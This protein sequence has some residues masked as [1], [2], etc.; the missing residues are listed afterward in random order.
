MKPRRFDVASFVDDRIGI[1]SYADGA[2]GRE[3][4][5]DCPFCG[6][7]SKFWANTITGLWTCYK[8]HAHGDSVGLVAE[9]DGVNRAQ[10]R[11]M[12][13][14]DLQGSVSSVADLLTQV[15]DSRPL[16]AEV[17]DGPAPDLCELPREFVP[18]WDPS[19]RQWHIPAYLKTRKIRPMVAA[20]FKL[21]YCEQGRYAARLILPLY[22]SGQLITFQARSMVGAMPKYLGPA[23]DKGGSL[24]GIDQALLSPVVA[25]VEGPIDV[26]GATQV[27][28]PAIGMMGKTI[29][30]AQ[31]LTIVDQGY[32]RVVVMLDPEARVD[33]VH[34]A[35]QLADVAN[36]A[37]AHLPPGVDPGDAPR[38]VILQ[39]MAAARPPRLSDR[40]SR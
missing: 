23:I 32:D 14:T 2:A 13:A 16:Q 28:V 5:T 6:G 12:I 25:L 27:G 31:I 11:V 33:A 22:Q 15:R 19:T 17:P 37:V 7:A 9:I 24:Y 10:A 35:R 3:A 4:V 39:A 29:S 21:G 30:P 8:C 1:K 38:E 36:V 18:I 20:T 34:V 40:I 26:L